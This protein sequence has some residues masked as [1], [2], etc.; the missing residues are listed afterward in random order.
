MGI[1]ISQL[2]VIATPALGDIFPVVQSGVTYQESFTQLSSLFATA[3]ANSNITS[4]TGLTGVIQAPTRIND[5]NSNAILSF[6][7]R[8]NAENYI[9]FINNVSGTPP[10]IFSSGTDADIDLVL[11]S[12]GNSAVIFSAA[13]TTP[14]IIFSGTGLQH[15]SNFV[16][17]DTNNL[18]TITFPDASGTV[19]LS[20]K[21]NGTEASNAVTASGTSGIITTS[22]LTLAGASNYA[23]TWTNTFITTS[24][25]ILLTI[26]GG[27]N[28]TENITLKATAGSGTSTLTIYNTSAAT[29]LNG[30]IL[31]G[32]MVIP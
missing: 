5:A 8:P 28:T 15:T 13:S 24:S 26:M 20:N 21:A 9:S 19:Y 4:L 31:I 23:I 2:P 1:K 22:S 12:K 14:F 3:G 6:E 16:F 11:M 17:S 7:A 30:T 27:T 29:A 18:R 10:S 32:Y 25:I